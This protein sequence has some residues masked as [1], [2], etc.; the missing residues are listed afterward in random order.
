M[1]GP[2]THLLSVEMRQ[3]RRHSQKVNEARKS[4]T[5]VL[6]LQPL[7]MVSAIL[8]TLLI[9]FLLLD[10]CK[11]FQTV[12]KRREKAT[13]SHRFAHLAWLW[14][15]A[16]TKIMGSAGHWVWAS[17]WAGPEGQYSGPHT[18]ATEFSSLKRWKFL[19]SL[20]CSERQKR[21][22]EEQLLIF[23]PVRNLD[24]LGFLEWLYPVF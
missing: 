16:W 21:R 6:T 23:C 11:R 17:D 2:Q 13:D 18:V 24:Q 9:F 22:E 1:V 19:T 10:N 7:L 4:S 3:K 20:V 8:T 12:K 14:K 5:N 15:G